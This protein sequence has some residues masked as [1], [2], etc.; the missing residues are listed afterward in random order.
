STGGV[1]TGGSSTGGSAGDMGT[2]GMGGM[3]GGGELPTLEEA[4]ES[5]CEHFA[6]LDCQDFSQQDCEDDCL[7]ESEAAVEDE[8]ESER[9]DFLMCAHGASDE[10][11]QCT[12]GYIF[13]DDCED[14][15]DAYWACV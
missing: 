4:C 10:T 8:C 7:V 14:E 15:E 6:T 2:A 12:G 9:L 1:G 11:I 3:G 13:P 5:M